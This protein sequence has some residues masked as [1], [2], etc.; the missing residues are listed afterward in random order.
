M[1]NA[2]TEKGKK[3]LFYFDYGDDWKFIVDATDIIQA[4]EGRLYPVLLNQSSINPEQYP[5]CEDE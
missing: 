5:P 2:F 1:K 3:M 4:E